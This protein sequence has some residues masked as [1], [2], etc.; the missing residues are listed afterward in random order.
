[1]VFDEIPQ[2]CIHL[3]YVFQ[4]RVSGNLVESSMSWELR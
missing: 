1:V 4:Y 2:I 3:G